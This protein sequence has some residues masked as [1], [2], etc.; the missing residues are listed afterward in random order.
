[1]IPRCSR[2][3]S[4]SLRHGG[5]GSCSCGRYSGARCQRTTGRCSRNAR[6]ATNRRLVGCATRFPLSPSIVRLLQNDATVARLRMATFPN[7]AYVARWRARFDRLT[8]RADDELE[9]EPEPSENLEGRDHVARRL[10]ELREKIGLTQAELAASLE[11]S[12]S[13]IS[14]WETG[15]AVVE[16]ELACRIARKYRTSLDW[17]Y[18]G[19]A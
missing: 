13:S 1:M 10:R 7:D 14:T 15:S 4:E 16:P 2:G 11:C 12:Q 3:G 5:L 9:P 6:A 19:A 8:Q 18:R 17:I